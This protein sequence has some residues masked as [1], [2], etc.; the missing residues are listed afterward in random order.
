MSA[1]IRKDGWEVSGVTLEDLELG[2]QAVQRA[3]ERERTIAPPDAEVQDKRQRGR[4]A[5]KNI[6]LAKRL[7][8]DEDRKRVLAFLRL[9]A[10][11]PDG[12]ETEVL[13]QKMSLSAK[14]AIS[15]LTQ[16]TNKLLSLV[17]LT[18]DAVYLGIKSPATAP[19]KW[20]PREQIADAIA[21]IE[22]LGV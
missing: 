14:Q 12:T 2:I 11:N 19:K 13:V 10:A 21:A 4:P 9:L 3:L 22:Q 17:D 7:K 1:T 15:G 18:P 6:A 5:T 16:I 20:F 8:T